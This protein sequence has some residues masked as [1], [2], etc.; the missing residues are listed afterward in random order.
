MAQINISVPDALKE[1]TDARVARGDYSS[2]SDLIRDLLRRERDYDARMAAFRDAI[3]AGY[4]SG[5]REVEPR[6][7]I[8]EILGKRSSAKAVA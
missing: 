6:A 2:P 8:D 1:W 4:A 7:L 3:D 5:F